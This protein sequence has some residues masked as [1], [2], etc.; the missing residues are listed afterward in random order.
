MSIHTGEKPFQCVVCLKRFSRSTLLYRHEKIHV[1]E[2]KFLCGHCDK[3]FLSND[4][5]ERHSAIHLKNRPFSCNICGKSFAFKQGMERHQITHEKEQPYSC[6]YCDLSFMTPS[7]L[8][9]H[10]T[11]H[12]GVRPYPCKLCPKSFLMSHHLTRHL[13]AHNVGILE[14]KCVDCGMTFS[15]RDDLIYHSAIHATEDLLCPLCKVHFDDIESVTDHIKLHSNA[16]QS[17]CD[18]CDLIFINSEDL[19]YHCKTQHFEDHKGND[20]LIKIEKLSHTHSTS[21][22]TTTIVTAK[23]GGNEDEY[24]IEEI[25]QMKTKRVR[26]VLSKSGQDIIKKGK[27]IPSVDETLTKIENEEV[28]AEFELPQETH[29]FSNTKAFTKNRPQYY[30]DSD[31]EADYIEAEPEEGEEEQ[32]GEEITNEEDH[33]NQDDADDGEQQEFETIEQ[34]M[35]EDDNYN[36]FEGF[37]IR[38]L[39]GETIIKM[40]IPDSIIAVP[41]KGAS[42]NTEPDQESSPPKIKKIQSPE[43]KSPKMNENPAL[44]PVKSSPAS[45]QGKITSF[46]KNNPKV[47][48][49]KNQ[50]ADVIKS[51]PKG[52]TIIKK[53]P[54]SE[55]KSIPANENT[56][57][58]PSFLE[59]AIPVHHKQNNKSIVD[60]EKIT[61]QQKSIKSNE[62]NPTVKQSPPNKPTT[63]LSPKGKIEPQVETP[64]NVDNQKKSVKPQ[65]T[66]NET[67]PK[68]T[69][70]T[71]NT[72]Q[73]PKTKSPVAA[74]AIPPTQSTSTESLTKALPSQKKSSSQ[75]QSQKKSPQNSTQ[76]SS[77]QKSTEPPKTPLVKKPADASTPTTPTTPTTRKPTDAPVSATLIQKRPS[78]GL[79]TSTPI[80]KYSIEPKKFV[81]KKSTDALSAP[82]P[83]PTKQTES[84]SQAPVRKQGETTIA[85][86]V[87]P[88]NGQSK[89]NFAVKQQRPPT[90]SKKASPST[91]T[92]TQSTPSPSVPTPSTATSAPSIPSSENSS[93]CEMKIGDRMVK[94]Q[95]LRMTKEQLDVMKREGKIEMKGGALIMK[96]SE[97]TKLV[98]KP[99][100][101]KS[102]S[103]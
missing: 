24:V 48:T 77:T 50:V 22:K 82:A 33:E 19:E 6:E 96:R 65:P 37:Q 23:S 35:S 21:P 42:K 40:E 34:P 94:V 49:E 53:E 27:P 36:E 71:P 102:V 4:E 95:K 86:V 98:P 69:A 103:F 30:S 56:D 47:K 83:A 76:K 67:S 57:N 101:I 64:V 70:K 59:P 14:Y 68:S 11:A 93:Y 9:R 58:E 44:P 92:P 2:P 46:F 90:E 100:Q 89:A 60:P 16:V 18:Y 79:T 51:L 78:T 29:T 81:Q 97:T 84:K 41:S 52:V 38:D 25:G 62:E 80:H 85:R 15:G 55:K 31:N 61:Q 39:D 3:S 8:A 5:L 63:K 87:Q 54:I 45:H 73:S 28:I 99:Q 10:L 17:P 12:A 72:T 91:P 7:K 32:E 1:D 26:P 75:N 13:R 43:M 20:I 74:K 88:S 66:K